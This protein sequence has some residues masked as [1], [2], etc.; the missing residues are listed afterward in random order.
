MFMPHRALTGIAKPILDNARSNPWCF[1]T[2][3]IWPLNV[4]HYGYTGALPVFM[5]ACV[6]SLV[7]PGGLLNRR[8]IILR[9]PASRQASYRAK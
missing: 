4:T 5:Q 9:P 8:G 6:C 2:I 3:Q 1:E 7:K